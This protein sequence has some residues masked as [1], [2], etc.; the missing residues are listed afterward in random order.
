M[1]RSNELHRG[2][3]NLGILLKAQ[4]RLQEA[5]AAYREAIRINPEYADAH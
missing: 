4:G 5:E 1:A 3:K 2:K